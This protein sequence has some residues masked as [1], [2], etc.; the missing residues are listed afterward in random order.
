MDG[1]QIEDAFL[2]SPPHRANTLGWWDSI[3]I[4]LQWGGDGRIRVAEEFGRHF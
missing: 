1:N 4:G 3:G 2:A